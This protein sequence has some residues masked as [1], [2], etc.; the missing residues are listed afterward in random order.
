MAL[1]TAHLVT[2]DAAARGVFG[3]ALWAALLKLQG[4]DVAVGCVS[5]TPLVVQRC[6]RLRLRSPQLPEAKVPRTDR[7][8]PLSDYQ[9]EAGAV[10]HWT[11]STRVD[12]TY[13]V[14]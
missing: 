11:W 7:F 10:F 3:S 12:L 8:S 9:E 6:L 13:L 1:P 14:G 2:S 5:G 4:P